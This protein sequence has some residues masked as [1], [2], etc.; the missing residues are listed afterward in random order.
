MYPI[1]NSFQPN[2]D[3]FRGPCFYAA[4]VG[5]AENEKMHLWLDFLKGKIEIF[6]QK[7]NIESIQTSINRTNQ[8]YIFQII[9]FEKNYNTGQT[10]WTE[11]T[12]KKI[13]SYVKWSK[14]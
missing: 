12:E 9:V 6:K 13:I 1:N 4:T 7:L 5:I 14:F 11:P 3:S 8:Q 2:F 10:D